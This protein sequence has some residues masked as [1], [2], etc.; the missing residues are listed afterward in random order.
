[1]ILYMENESNLEDQRGCT[2]QVIFK[3]KPEEASQSREGMHGFWTQDTA[4]V[5][6]LMWKG[7]SKEHKDW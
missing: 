2:E 1:M 5:H 4:K 3:L 6:A 7:A